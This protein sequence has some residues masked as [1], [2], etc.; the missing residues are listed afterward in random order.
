M[1]RGVGSGHSVCCVGRL[2]VVNYGRQRKKEGCGGYRMP[3]GLV[4]KAEKRAQMQ[5]D[6]NRKSPRKGKRR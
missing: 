2:V 1:D 3:G 5:R 4:T 6:F